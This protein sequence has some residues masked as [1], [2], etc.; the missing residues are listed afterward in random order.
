[1]TELSRISSYNLHY[2]SSMDHTRRSN[3]MTE[4]GEN[5]LILNEYRR[6]LDRFD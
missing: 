1:M 3:A 6:L 4:S 2:R 5:F